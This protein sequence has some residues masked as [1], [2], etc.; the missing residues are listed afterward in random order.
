MSAAVR[1]VLGLFALLA[2]PALSKAASGRALYSLYLNQGVRVYSYLGSRNE[3]GAGTYRVTTV[4]TG[5]K[6][7]YPRGRKQEAYTV[8]CQ[9]ARPYV[10]G[11][12]GRMEIDQ[13]TSP[14]HAESTRYDLW[15]A[16]CRGVMRKF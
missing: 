10:S 16:V 13:R 11:K 6:S 2:S 9:D 8:G 12:E 7:V 1:T 4:S 15:W 14:S 3:V 5:P